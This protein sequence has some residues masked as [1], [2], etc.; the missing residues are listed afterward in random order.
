MKKRKGS[1]LK[2]VLSVW[3]SEPLRDRFEE[4]CMLADL[5]KAEVVESLIEWFLTKEDDVCL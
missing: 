3:I 1:G 2:K 5:N 4:V